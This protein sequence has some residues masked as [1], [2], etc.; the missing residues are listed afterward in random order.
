MA[1]H[2]APDD[3][4]PAEP[5]QRAAAELVEAPQAIP[6]RPP[7]PPA[8]NG[9]ARAGVDL[10]ALFDEAA[11]TAE[12]YKQEAKAEAQALLARAQQTADELVANAQRE[13][14]VQFRQHLRDY[15]IGHLRELDAAEQ[16]A[17]PE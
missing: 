10:A 1:A 13:A 4:D 8:Q 15:H 5:A 6:V 2:A 16:A 12:R 11:A 3:Q 9:P 14:N 17:S 7:P